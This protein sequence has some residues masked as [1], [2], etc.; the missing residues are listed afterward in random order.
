MKN[1]S[2]V[3][4]VLYYRYSYPS[5]SQFLIYIFNFFRGLNKYFQEYSNNILEEVS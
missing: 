5:D 2:T 4:Q 1:I 3:V